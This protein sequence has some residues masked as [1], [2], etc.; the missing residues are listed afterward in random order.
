MATHGVREGNATLTVNVLGGKVNPLKWGTKVYVE[1]RLGDLVVQ[2]L[3]PVNVDQV[4]GDFSYDG[5]VDRSAEFD[6]NTLEE[7]YEET[8]HIVLRS[9]SPTS[10]WVDSAQIRIAVRSISIDAT[11]RPMTDLGRDA[12]DGGGG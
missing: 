7:I 5:V 12:S 9:W 1:A 6:D 11:V 4:S 3:S 8:L 2:R 10:S